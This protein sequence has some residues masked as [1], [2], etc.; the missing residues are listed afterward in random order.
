MSGHE[1]L[2]GLERGRAALAL[3]L[4]GAPLR[5]MHQRLAALGG[6]LPLDG[7]ANLQ[8]Q[9][10]QEFEDSVLSTNQGHD[11]H[12]G[13]RIDFEHGSRF[14]HGKRIPQRGGF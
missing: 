3:G 5:D 4:E 2:A 11:E 10:A 8:I 6:K 14:Q 9:R 1:T 13:V 12:L 7:V